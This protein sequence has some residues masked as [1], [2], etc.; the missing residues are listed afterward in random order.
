MHKIVNKHWKVLEINPEG[1]KHFRII[2]LRH[3]KETKNLQEL[4]GCHTNKNGKAFKV[5]S[6]NRK[7][8]WEF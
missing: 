7:G 1:A 5:H 2:R 4:I 6:K 8:K 3:L